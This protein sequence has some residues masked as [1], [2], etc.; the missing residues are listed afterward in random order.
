[1]QIESQHT[2]QDPLLADLY[3][4]PQDEARRALAFR[5]APR[6]RFD[7]NEP[8]LPLAA[9][10]TIFH[11]DAPSPSYTKGRTV[12]L[13]PPEQ[14][15]ST[16]AI[17]YA[18]WWDWDIGH[19]YELEHVWVYVDAGGQVVRAEASWHGDYHD[20]RTDRGLSIE[21]GHLVICSEPG[22]HAFAPTPDWFRERWASMRRSPTADLAGLGGLLVARYFE[23][24]IQKTP[25][26]DRLVATYLHRHAFEPSWRF[27]QGFSFSRQMFVPWPALRA[28]IPRRVNS[29]LDRLAHEIDPSAYRVL[30]I[31]HRGARA[32]APDNTLA[33]FRK[34]AELGADMVELDL[35]RTADGH[36]VVVHDTFLHDAERQVW[37][38]QQST[39]AALRQIDLGDG[40][41][42]PTLSEA[43]EVCDQQQLGA[44][45]ELK[46]GSVV[47]D[48][49]PL[50]RDAGWVSRC[51]VGS[52]RP[53]WLAEL[54]AL[55]PE[56]VT[57][58][59]FGSLH[60][61]PVAL[62][63][64]VGATYVH[65]CWERLPRP[66]AH[67]TPGWIHRVRRAG[68]GVIAWHEER[69]EEIVTL[70]QR[71]IDGICSDAPELLREFSSTLGK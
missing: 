41:R 59:L 63:Q 23:G 55:A 36:L 38:V 16:T 71:G 4:V 57:S 2:P 7:T 62:A 60:V 21:D 37:P 64:S 48:L 68:L 27:D 47:Q 3:A 18:I 42:V 13:S 69:P 66:S 50:L 5:Y 44:Y 58:V 17:E 1:M 14:G 70:R 26:A 22:K 56:I 54:K 6:L 28:W 35:Q 51:L 52:F 29:W 15:S 32:H 49:V 12:S 31:G 33:G 43:L 45:I 65:P 40:E 39:M 46:D 11:E 67:L 30:R 20:M 19:L 8:F 10:Y 25:L 61:D 24:Q 9:G 53:D 34:A